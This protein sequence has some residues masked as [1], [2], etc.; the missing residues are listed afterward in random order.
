MYWWHLPNEF[1]VIIAGIFGASIGSFLHVC[2]WR[3]PREES[4]VFPASRCPECKTHI[5]WYDNLPLISWLILCGACRH[6]KTRIPVRYP[7]YE[8]LTALF[9]MG[10]VHIYG[11]SSAT[12]LYI[13]LVCDL[14]V[15][16]GIDWD[17]QYIPDILSL[18]LIPASLVIA[19]IAQWLEYFPT[20]LVQGI[21][22]ALW[23]IIVG[24]G[25]IWAIRIVGTWVFKQEAMGFGDVK[26]MA[27]LGG[28][29]GW[30]EALLCIFLA[31]FIGSVVGVSLKYSGRIGKYGHIPFGPYLALGAYICFLYGNDIILWYT[32]PFGR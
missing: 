22:P 10:V 7:I 11:I 13:F 29:I 12:F 27:F 19:A 25:V 24:G 17:H 32:A 6:C 2:I 3:I 31:A 14:I 21:Y 16:S 9:F 1:F 20:A 15:A 4:I 28:F 8:M 30:Q 5:A 18:P 23:G 26:L